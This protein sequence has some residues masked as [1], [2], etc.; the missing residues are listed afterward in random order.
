MSEPMTSGAKPPKVFEVK[1]VWAAVE[2]PAKLRE[3]VIEGLAR[4]GEV[5]NAVAATKIGKS[6][7]A[8]GLLFCGATGGDWLGRLGICDRRTISNLVA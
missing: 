4:R 1:S 3:C 8:L 2:H 7:L 5:V 6:W